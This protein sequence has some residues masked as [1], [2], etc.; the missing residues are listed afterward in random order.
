MSTNRVLQ[1]LIVLLLAAFLTPS[2]ACNSHNG[3][4]G[5]GTPTGPPPPLQDSRQFRAIAGISM[6]AYGAM[7]LGTKHADLFGA[8]AS[9]GG[10]VDMQQ[11]LR[12]SIE[13]NLEVKAQTEIPRQVDDDFTYDHLPSYPDRDTRVLMFQDLTSAFG[14]PFLHHPDANKQYL[15]SDSEPARI[16]RD[17]QF[18][19]FTVPTDPRGFLD[20]GDENQDGLRQTSEEPNLLTDVSLLAK[21]SLPM[22]VSG[23]TPVDV[24]G[25]AL[26]DLNGDGVYDVG[27]GLIVNL[28]EPFED[29]NGNGVFDAGEQFSDVGLDG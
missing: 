27:E 17:D 24:G 3:N 2:G 4:G 23:A 1:P 5:G 8:I 14:N 7:N 6:G 22:I 9:L 28:S 12:D 26:A 18:G 11:L 25:R 20:G 13:D 29:T 16:G 19:T 10:P 21:G 15:G